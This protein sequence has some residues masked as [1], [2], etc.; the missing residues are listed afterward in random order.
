MFSQRHGMYR[1]GKYQGKFFQYEQVNEKAKRYNQIVQNLITS[2][3]S[4]VIMTN[5]VLDYKVNEYIELQ[6]GC[7]YIING[8]QQAE[9][10]INPQA[11]AVVKSGVDTLY[12]MELIKIE[13]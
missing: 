11:Y 3:T 13:R 2:E 5:Y 7:N 12:Y 4:T 6:D 9:E 10:D 1:T 8:I